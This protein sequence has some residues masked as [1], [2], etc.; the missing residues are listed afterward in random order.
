MFFELLT[1]IAQTQTAPYHFHLSQGFEL[2][3]ANHL[4]G[5]DAIRIIHLFCPLSKAFYKAIWQ[6]G[7]QPTL[8]P[9]YHGCSPHRRREGA[10]LTQD[11]L[12]YRLT[13][14]GIP[15][16]LGP[17]DQKN[18][19]GCTNTQTQIRTATELAR[20][21]HLTYVNQHINSFALRMPCYN[22]EV[23]VKI[24]QGGPQGNPMVV[25]LFGHSFKYPIMFWQM[26]QD[27]WDDNSRACWA[28][29]PI[30]NTTTDLSLTCFVDDLEKT[31]LIPT[32]TAHEV[33]EKTTAS[34][35]ALNLHLTNAGYLQ[36]EA[37]ETITPVLFGPGSQHQ[38]RTLLATDPRIKLVARYLGTLH[39]HRLS[40]TPKLNRLVKA[41]KIGFAQMGKIWSTPGIPYRTKRVVLLSK[42]CRRRP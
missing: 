37:K 20:P 29:C 22:G 12:S 41:A 1:C 10:I 8:P 34:N 39:H 18:A 9:C 35:E 27:R 36:N 14:A 28:T 26:A 25:Q 23:V 3:K 19:F 7:P 30:T 5:V 32:G 21:D 24:G 38:L 16:M 40:I 6:L 31:T 17:K 13:S 15:H 42:V 2:D 4:K 33:T 11:N